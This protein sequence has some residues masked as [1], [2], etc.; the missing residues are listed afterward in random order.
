MPWL[1]DMQK[2]NISKLHKPSELCRVDKHHRLTK[3]EEGLNG[4]KH[5]PIG[6][7]V[8][9]N[10]ALVAKSDNVGC[11]VILKASPTILPLFFFFMP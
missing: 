11:V 3:K 6:C 2:A 9:W 5:N 10:T 4:D 8:I 7:C 1:N